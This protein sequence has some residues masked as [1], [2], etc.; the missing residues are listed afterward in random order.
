M[1]A[2]Q[3]RA[4]M[5]AMAHAHA[6]RMQ[7]ARG[8]LTV[9]DA[10]LL[11]VAQGR[12]VDDVA[13]DVALDRLVL[14]HHGTGGLAADAVHMAAR[15][16]RAVGSARERGAGSAAGGGGR[17]APVCVR[18]PPP[19]RASQGPVQ[20][21]SA[22]VLLAS[23][24]AGYR[25]CAPPRQEEP[26]PL[27]TAAIHPTSRRAGTPS[28]PARAPHP[29]PCL[30]RPRFRRFF[31]MFAPCAE[32]AA[33]ERHEQEGEAGEGGGSLSLSLCPAPPSLGLCPPCVFWPFPGPRAP[34]K[35]GCKQWVAGVCNTRRIAERVQQ[36][37]PPP[38]V[39]RAIMYHVR[40]CAA[41]SPYPISTHA[42]GAPTDTHTR[43]PAIDST[44][45]VALPRQ[46]RWWCLAYL[47]RVPGRPA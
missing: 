32:R 39:A 36:R 42:P 14:R 20:E 13:H 21:R 30:A 12:G 46:Q 5:R 15:R 19:T 44:D 10:R 29:R 31:V 11:H 47:A 40:P 27:L 26:Q 9:H 4:Y 45:V 34:C 2:W 7:A 16:T 37:A 3:F 25:C 6:R 23:A 41:C 8:R 38:A 1:R 22:E 17:G 35:V 28:A 43:N 33:A 18:R 24:A